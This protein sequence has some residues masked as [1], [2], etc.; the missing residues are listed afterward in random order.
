MQYEATVPTA[1]DRFIQQAVL[2]VVQRYLDPTFS[3]R[4]YGFRPD[5]S[6]KATSGACSLDSRIPPPTVVSCSPFCAISAPAG[7]TRDWSS[8]RAAPSQRAS[9]CAIGTSTS[10]LYIYFQPNSVN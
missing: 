5:L 10:P 1:L 8:F 7:R 6:L 2:Q 3:E 4:S 9:N